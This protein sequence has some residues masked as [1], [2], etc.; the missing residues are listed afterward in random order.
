MSTTGELCPGITPHWQSTGVGS[1]AGQ[2]HLGGVREIVV[3]LVSLTYRSL[4]DCLGCQLSSSLVSHQHLT[5]SPETSSVLL[6]LYWVGNLKPILCRKSCIYKTM[7]P[8]SKE[9]PACAFS[10]LDWGWDLLSVRKN[11]CLI[12]SSSKCLLHW[13]L[14]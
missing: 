3:C 5:V 12:L 9:H 11:S 1:N 6:L 7:Q 14:L 8:G 13:P 4:H 10:F 2:S